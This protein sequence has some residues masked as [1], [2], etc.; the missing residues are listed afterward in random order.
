MLKL[1]EKEVSYWLESAPKTSY[2]TLKK[3][4]EVDVVI[5]GG[6]IS[7]VTAAYLLK[8]AGKTVAVVEKGTIGSGTTG[9]TT[10]KV[11]SQH[12]I[13]YSDLQKRLGEKIARI[14]GEANQT[15]IEEIENVI[16]KENISCDWERDDNYVYTREAEKVATYKDE[17]K[18]AQKLGLPATFETTTSLPFDVKGAVKFANQAQ[19][20]SGKYVR[21]LAEKI[22]GQGNFVFENTRALG[23]FDGTPATVKTAHG[24]IHAK[25]IIVATNVPTLPLMARGGYCILEYPQKSYIVAARIPK[26]FKGMYISTDKKEY[27]ILPV[28]VGE[29]HLLLVGGESHIPGAKLNFQERYQR[30]ADYA[31]ERFGVTAIDYRWSARDYQAY[32]DIPLVGKLYPWSKHVYVVTAFRKWGLANSMVSGIIL[33]DL[34]LEQKNEWAQVYDSTRSEPIASIPRV[35]MQY[36]TGSK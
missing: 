18:V 22:M 11:T 19:F 10:G 34:I 28:T 27:S 13:T 5:V 3:D 35:A 23:I 14:Y 15:A 17:A 31:E 9:H 16:Q 26:K 33:R 29:E 24:T 2:P 30:L 12:S 20:H 1:P 21:G 7:G 32:D 4:I 8:K 6:G 36:L 25:D